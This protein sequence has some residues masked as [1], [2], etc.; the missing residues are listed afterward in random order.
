MHVFETKQNT[1]LVNVFTVQSVNTC[2]HYTA[3]KKK[4][5]FSLFLYFFQWSSRV[6]RMHFT[7]LVA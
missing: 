5:K 6:F 2:K 3:Q 4:F 7:L 1:M